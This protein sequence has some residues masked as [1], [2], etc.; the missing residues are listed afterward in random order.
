MPTFGVM[1]TRSEFMPNSGKVKAHRDDSWKNDYR[2]AITMLQGAEPDAVILLDIGETD[3]VKDIKNKFKRVSKDMGLVASVR[4]N[5]A[6]QYGVYLEHGKTPALSTYDKMKLEA[7][8]RGMTVSQLKA[9]KAA[10]QAANGET[11][12]ESTGRRGRPRKNAE[13]PELATV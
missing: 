9:E 11:V 12:A 5:S 2:E 1:V 4:K 10:E 7:E 8:S 3:D 6:G 13:T